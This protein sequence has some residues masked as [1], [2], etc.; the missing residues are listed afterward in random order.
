MICLTNQDIFISC[1]YITCKYNIFRR[2]R[3]V[4]RECNFI[5]SSRLFCVGMIDMPVE[6]TSLCTRR[7]LPPLF[8]SFVL[9]KK[10]EIFHAVPGVNH[11]N[12]ISAWTR[13]RGIYI[14]H[15]FLHTPLLSWEPTRMET[16]R[17]RT[18]LAAGNVA[19]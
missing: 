11:C 14:P 16:Q 8:S 1:Y 15:S 18:V 5:F 9:L 12:A 2:L 4:V 6:F 13:E 7:T 3:F 19:V 10:L 17:P